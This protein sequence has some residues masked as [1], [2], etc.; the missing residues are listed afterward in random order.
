MSKSRQRKDIRDLNRQSVQAPILES[1][2]H[3][4]PL[5]DKT[6]V[7]HFYEST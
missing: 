6:H 4:L 3:R 2:Q 1:I 7:V 5:A